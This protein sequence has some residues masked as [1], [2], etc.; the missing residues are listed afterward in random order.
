MLKTVL[1][2][3]TA[4]PEEFA[5]AFVVN[6]LVLYLHNICLSCHSSAN[7]H[8]ILAHNI[9][10]YS[11]PDCG[12]RSAMRKLSEAL[13]SSQGRGPEMAR[14]KSVPNFWKKSHQQRLLLSNI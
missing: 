14:N 7:S 11:L 3:E 9:N 6:H 12:S 10:G 5:V 13:L 8:Y 2:L 1:A 4:T